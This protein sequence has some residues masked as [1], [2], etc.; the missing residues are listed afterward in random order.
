[1]RASSLSRWTCVVALACA[2]AAPLA[3]QQRLEGRLDAAT[4]ATLRPVFEL[5]R[6]DS[7]PVTAL[8]DKALEGAAKRIPAERIVAAVQQLARDLRDAR[9]LLRGAR[10][11]G[12]IADGEV[13]A[14]ADAP[15]RGVPTA[16]IAALAANVPPALSLLVP[17]TVLGDLVQRGVPAA[18]ARQV[19]QE[20]LAAG[21]S[22][23]QLAEIPARVDVAL[24][25]G[26]QPREAFFNALPIPVRPP[27]P[28]QRPSGPPSESS[29]R[30][31]PPTP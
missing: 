1:M 27:V 23:Q 30:I 22:P 19:I 11:S 25:V 28:Q 26:A 29:V 7:V 24:R 21:I 16:E 2:G 10:P 13:L 8:E 3:G 6:R 5:A 4:L 20:L 31:G 18:E 12:A 17:L 15:R 14:A 9:V